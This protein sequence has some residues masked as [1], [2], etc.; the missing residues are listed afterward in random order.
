MAVMASVDPSGPAVAQEDALK[1]FVSTPTWA[2][3]AR[4]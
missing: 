1:L 2:R 3:A 4:R